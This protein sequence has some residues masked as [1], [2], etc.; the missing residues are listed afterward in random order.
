MENKE[1]K[2]FEKNLRTFKSIE[3]DKNWLDS[4]RFSIV[5]NTQIR[6]KQ[7]KSN[8]RWAI[9]LSAFLIVIA[10]GGGAVTLADTSL[11]GDPLYPVKRSVEEIRF[12]FA[13]VET[14]IQLQQEF[15]DRRIDELR[16]LATHGKSDKIEQAF[17]EVENYISKANQMVSEVPTQSDQINETLKDVASNTNDQIEEV[18]Q[19]DQYLPEAADSDIQQTQDLLQDLKDTAEKKIDDA[20]LPQDDSQPPLEENNQQPS[21]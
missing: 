2:D 19:I 12:N 8:Y 15:T 14:K 4:L 20:P 6:T 16:E 18:K 10:L 9:S 21:Q 5:G 13:D 11:P 3:P 17:K 7:T 1:L